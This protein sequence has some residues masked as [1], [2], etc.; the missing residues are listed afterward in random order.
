[1]H[2]CKLSPF[3]TQLTSNQERLQHLKNADGRNLRGYL[4]FIITETMLLMI[5]FFVVAAI[6]C[7]QPPAI[8]NGKVEGSELQWGSSVAYSC[9]SGYQLSSPGIATC[10]GN[11]TWR[12]EIPQCLRK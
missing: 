12:G 9:F 4:E 3:H 2:T 10:E 11:G 5:M 8:D 1:M 7:G 6:M